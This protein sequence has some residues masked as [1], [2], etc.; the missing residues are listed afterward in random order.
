MYADPSNSDR[1]VAKPDQLTQPSPSRKRV[2]VSSPPRGANFDQFHTTVPVVAVV[3]RS[4][5][6][7]AERAPWAVSLLRYPPRWIETATGQRKAVWSGSRR[8]HLHTLVT[9]VEGY[10]FAP[11]E[12][13]P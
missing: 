4:A 8:E 1:R 7:A 5:A 9:G 6:L 11:T 12:W 13:E 2:P 3:P 10:A